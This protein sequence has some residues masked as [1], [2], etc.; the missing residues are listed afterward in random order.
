M[1]KVVE[2]PGLEGESENVPEKWSGA[3]KSLG[4]SQADELFFSE[5]WVYSFSVEQATVLVS[6]AGQISGREGALGDSRQDSGNTL[7]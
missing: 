7:D 2:R 4:G 6:A 1:G 5:V 3:T